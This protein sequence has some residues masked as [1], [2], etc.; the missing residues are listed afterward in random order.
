M[1]T[2]NFNRTG[3]ERAAIL[4][5]VLDTRSAAL[6]FQNLNEIQAEA[7]RTELLQMKSVP[8][9]ITKP[10]FDDFLEETRFLNELANEKEEKKEDR[11]FRPDPPHEMN[12]GRFQREKDLPENEAE[13][14]PDQ[15]DWNTK[16]LKIFDDADEMEEGEESESDLP[17]IARLEKLPH[18]LPN[19]HFSRKEKEFSGSGKNDSP[20]FFLQEMDTKDLLSLLEDERD[21]TVAGIIRYLPPQKQ[22]EVFWKFPV[23]KQEILQEY[24]D[25]QGPVNRDLVRELERFLHEKDQK[26]KN[27]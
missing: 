14:D 21:S 5:S 23:R 4:F 25:H 7:L 15:E 22:K 18:S 27:G 2:A 13:E 8:D 19:P 26:R 10:I 1:S 3:L 9:R 17:E 24:L 16:I 12:S 20:F 6:L 11:E